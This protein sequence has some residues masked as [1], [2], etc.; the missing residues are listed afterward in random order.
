MNAVFMLILFISET[1]V[2]TYDGFLTEQEA[3]EKAFELDELN[4]RNNSITYVVIPNFDSI[5]V[6][7]KHC[8]ANKDCSGCPYDGICCSRSFALIRDKSIAYKALDIW[9]HMTF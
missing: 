1:I 8:A 9:S 6:A 2:D 4:Q 5:L 3:W 7:S